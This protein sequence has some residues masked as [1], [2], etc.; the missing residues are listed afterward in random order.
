MGNSAFPSPF[1]E[2][3]CCDWL[4]R[5][6]EIVGSSFP[7]PFGEVV[8]CDHPEADKFEKAV[9]VSVPFRGSGLL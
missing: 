8:C 3:V 1:G 7:S 6:G 2:V 4:A 9:D 5:R